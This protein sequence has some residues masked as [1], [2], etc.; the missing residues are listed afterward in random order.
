MYLS[1]LPIF[2][3]GNPS[4]QF[5]LDN[6]VS[7]DSLADRT[8]FFV[9]LDLPFQCHFLGNCHGKLI[10]P[11]TCGFIIGY[12]SPQPA[13]SWQRDSSL[14]GIFL[15]DGFWSLSWHR[16]SHFLNLI[17]IHLHPFTNYFMPYFL[18][19]TSFTSCFMHFYA[20][21]SCEHQGLRDHPGCI[22]TQ[23][24]RWPWVA[25]LLPAPCNLAVLGPAVGQISW[26]RMGVDED[27]SWDYDVRY[28][29]G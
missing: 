4:Y 8:T 26:D 7:P 27:I 10:K 18:A 28:F 3:S 14:Q 1:T 21:F 25:R 9:K 20:M 6:G 13:K 17:K 22:A 2:I 15:A 29:F 11:A 12:E 5:I 16:L 19:F 24:P 23:L